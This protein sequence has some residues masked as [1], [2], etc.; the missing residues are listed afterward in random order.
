MKGYINRCTHW[1]ACY[2]LGTNHSIHD[3]TIHTYKTGKRNLLRF[4][5]RVWRHSNFQTVCRRTRH[6][7]FLDHAKKSFSTWGSLEFMLA[8]FSKRHV[9]SMSEESKANS[10]SI[11]ENCKLWGSNNLCLFWYWFFQC[12]CCKIIFKPLKGAMSLKR[13]HWK[14]AGDFLSNCFL[15]GTYK[16]YNKFSWF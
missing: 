8:A 4:I 9:Q 1:D 15:W 5:T 12:P 16:L 13:K 7:Y 2:H 14:S 10:T 3:D 11:L 6:N